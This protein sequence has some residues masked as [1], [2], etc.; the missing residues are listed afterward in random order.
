MKKI[1][2]ALLALLVL[3]SCTGKDPVSATVSVFESSAVKISEATSPEDVIAV[4]E[5]LTVELDSV[6]SLYAEAFEKLQLD[7]AAFSMAEEK[8]TAVAADFGS[9][10]GDK[11]K[12]VEITPAQA[13]K[14]IGL[15]QEVE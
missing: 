10:L 13:K 11:L 7:S 4:L 6:K 1:M 12:E 9:K 14:I 3:A 8:L 2:F 15:I 5:V